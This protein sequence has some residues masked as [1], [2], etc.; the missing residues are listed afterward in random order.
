MI[1]HVEIFGGELFEHDAPA[2]QHKIRA[3][4]R[5]WRDEVLEQEDPQRRGVQR[6]IERENDGD[7]DGTELFEGLLVVQRF[8]ESA[9]WVPACCQFPEEKM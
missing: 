2:L 4:T 9:R 8:P 6:L 3:E 5:P 1:V 7:G